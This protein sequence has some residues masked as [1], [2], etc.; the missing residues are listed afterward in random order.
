M[1]EVHFRQE[2]DVVPMARVIAVALAALAI[3]G[4]GTLWAYFL[5]QARLTALLPEGAIT[6]PA[7]ANH[8]TVGMV[9]HR[10]YGEGG[11]PAE[12]LADEQALSEFGWQSRAD[13]TVRIP[14]ERAMDL[15][16]AGRSP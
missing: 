16:I 9:I 7:E 4:G 15:V 6:V 11:L 1:S 13:G 2:D 14:I 5:M 10:F 8:S 12:R 3:F